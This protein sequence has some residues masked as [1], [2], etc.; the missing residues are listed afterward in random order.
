MFVDILGRIQQWSGIVQNKLDYCKNEVNNLGKE[1]L[2][3][4]CEVAD[5]KT[6][7]TDYQNV[8]EK[9]FMSEIPYVSD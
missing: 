5:L 7:I 4:A 6:Q 1:F 8:R 2:A 3:R 9:Y